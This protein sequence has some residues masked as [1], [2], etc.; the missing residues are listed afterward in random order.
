MAA[1]HFPAHNG[2]LIHTVQYLFL[3][4]SLKG[5]EYTGPLSLVEW[6]QALY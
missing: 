4:G 1:I 5:T 6:Y 2:E 3:S